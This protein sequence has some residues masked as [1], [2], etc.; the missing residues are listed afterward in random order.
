MILGVGTLTMLVASCLDTVLP[1][2]RHRSALDKYRKEQ[3]DAYEL[4][5]LQIGEHLTKNASGRSSS[6]IESIFDGWKGLQLQ[7][8]RSASTDS[9]GGT[10]KAN[11]DAVTSTESPRTLEVPV[12]QNDFPP[13]EFVRLVSVSA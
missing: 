5:E 7:Y 12:Q 2:L 8:W 11:D 4:L 9:V 13:H 1:R 10:V 3:W 6:I